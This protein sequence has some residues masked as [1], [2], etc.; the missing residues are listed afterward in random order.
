MIFAKVKDGIV[1]DVMV[2]DQDFMDN[3]IDT[4]AGTWIETKEDGS[5]RKNYAGIGYTYD[6]TKNAFI[7]PQP[8]PSWKLNESTCRWE[9]P[10]TY[11]DDGKVY[12]WNE[13]S[14]AWDKI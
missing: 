8:Y 2:A 13:T 1:D 9:A 14:K 10:A 3:F 12:L 4:S 7:P 6:E 5:I 11:P